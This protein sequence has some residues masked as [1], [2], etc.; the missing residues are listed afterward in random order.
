MKRKKGYTKARINKMRK[1][2][3]EKRKKKIGLGFSP[4]QE[5]ASG[6][7]THGGSRKA[8]R[9]RERQAAKREIRDQQD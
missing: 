7:G 9:K 8:R 4:A 5:T 2:K 3:K 1:Q 6:A